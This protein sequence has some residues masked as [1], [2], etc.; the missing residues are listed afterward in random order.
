MLGCAISRT[1]TM[2][3]HRSQLPA[4]QASDPQVD[5]R[6]RAAQD[7]QVARTNLP[8]LK[9]LVDSIFPRDVLLVPVVVDVG[10]IAGVVILDLPELSAY[11]RPR[12][13]TLAILVPGPH[14]L[15]GVRRFTADSA[16][17]TS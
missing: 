12:S 16:V 2:P 3:P 1:A 14:D 5:A 9:R 7:R 17:A 15:I 11:I 6:S 4:A 10:G 8:F 13:T